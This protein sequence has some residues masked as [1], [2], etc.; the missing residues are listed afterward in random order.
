MLK[1][2]LIAVP[3]A[4]ALLGLVIAI[5]PGAFRITR[6]ARLSA[7]A[8]EL[9]AVVN[10]FR[11]W[12]AWSPWEGLDPALKRNYSG[13]SAGAGAIYSWAGNSQAG[14]GLMTILESQPND[15]I[16]I[17]LEFLKPFAATHTAEFNFKPE[18]D[19]TIVT[20]LCPGGKERMRRLM[21]MIA[22]GR[23]DLTPLVTHRFA[24]GDIAEAFEVFSAQRDNVFK[25]A[26][27][28]NG[29][30]ALKGA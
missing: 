16:R 17:R 28:P 15:F 3:I 13:S 12:K 6:S 25:V 26:L 2:V 1:I 29:V 23:V 5:Q 8:A 27:Y 30:P 11:R 10:D 24:L 21:T 9:F 22:A 20:S 7:P 18:G 14:E 19:Q 4:V